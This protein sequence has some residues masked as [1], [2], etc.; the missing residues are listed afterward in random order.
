MNFYF[1]NTTLFYLTL[2]F[3]YLVTLS[4]ESPH[5]REATEEH[6]NQAASGTFSDLRKKG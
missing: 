2:L 1:Q 3:K 4:T 5:S 6:I